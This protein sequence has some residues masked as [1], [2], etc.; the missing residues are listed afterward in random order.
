M[1]ENVTLG[2]SSSIAGATFDIL[3]LFPE[4]NFTG[5][6]D[7]MGKW[8]TKNKFVSLLFL[9]GYKISCNVR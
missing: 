7:E 3:E 2:N 1:S 5:L 6:P 4:F 9:H 8:E